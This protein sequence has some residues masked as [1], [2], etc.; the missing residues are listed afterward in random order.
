MQDKEL[1][2]TVGPLRD[3][4][5]WGQVLSF[6]RIYYTH[7]GMGTARKMGRKFWGGGEGLCERWMGRQ[8]LEPR[9]WR[10]STWKEG[11]ERGHCLSLGAGP[12][13]APPPTLCC[14]RGAPFTIPFP[15]PLPPKTLRTL[16]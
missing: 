14:G 5:P 12:M 11:A 6:V 3:F 13:S 8:V 4:L 1:N 16:Q 9:W 15:R 10:V 2:S 7:R